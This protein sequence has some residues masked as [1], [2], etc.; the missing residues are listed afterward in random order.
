MAHTRIRPFTGTTPVGVGATYVIVETRPSDT[1]IQVV[2]NGTVTFTVDTTLQNI[3]YDANAL[4]AVNLQTLDA[5]RYVAPTAAIWT[6][7]IASGSISARAQLTDNAV[8]AFRINITA[9]A[10]GSVTYA[11]T[12]G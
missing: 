10:A 9:G 1:D 2:A 5:S 4:N 11:I 12:Q 6:N 8:Y 7:L 3:T